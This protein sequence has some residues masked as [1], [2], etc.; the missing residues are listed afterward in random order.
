MVSVL[1][2]DDDAA[3][4]RALREAYDNY[5]HG[6]ETL[7]VPG[8]GPALD[9]MADRPVDAV[10]TSARLSGIGAASFLRLTKQQHPR[11]ARIALSNPG[12]RSAMLRTLPVANQCLSRSCGQSKLF[13]AAT[14]SL[15][16]ISATWCGWPTTW[17]RGTTPAPR[18]T[19]SSTWT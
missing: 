15:A 7:F 9:T 14:Q 4:L 19:T 2:V 1:F 17:R 6:W 11:T 16:L 13:T 8:A 3:C 10:V 18:T 12:D 5:A